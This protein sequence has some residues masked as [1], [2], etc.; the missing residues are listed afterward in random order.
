[1]VP[2]NR[3]GSR[4]IALTVQYDGTCFNGWQLQDN[5]R[6]VQ[7]E[8]EAALK[9]LTRDNIRVVASGRTDTGVHAIGQV[10]HFN[11]TS[12]IP[13]QRLC[14]GMNGILESDLSVK[15]AYNVDNTFHARFSAIEREYRYLIYN[16]P[17]RSPFMRYRA[18]WAREPLDVEYIND[19][20]GH[21]V[22]EHDF[23]SFCK[24][25]SASENENTVRSINSA[26]ACMKGEYIEIKICG[27]AFLHNMIRIIIGTV[28]EMGR[29]GYPPEHISEI[30]AQKD[31]DAG[32]YTAPAYGLYLSRVMYDPGL[33]TMDSAF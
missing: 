27:N 22:G 16:N 21:T 10:I 17:Q 33:E 29:K 25:R 12:S 18:M 5:G 31:R 3:K 30:I 2:G 24:K 14:I 32:G 19:V 4:R 8:I 7:G 6:T 11:T 15:N 23:A 13:L 1:M 28:V 9:V 26:R 20:L